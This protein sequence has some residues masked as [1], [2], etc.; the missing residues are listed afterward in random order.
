MALALAYAMR[1][2][3]TQAVDDDDEQADARRVRVVG[4]HGW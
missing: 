4:L 3:V 2:W 1:R